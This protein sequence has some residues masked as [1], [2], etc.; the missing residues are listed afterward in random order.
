MVDAE[1][2]G[3]SITVSTRVV[4]SWKI[5]QKRFN[6]ECIEVLVQH[7]HFLATQLMIVAGRDNRM[8]SLKR[9]REESLSKDLSMM[10]SGKAT[11]RQPATRVRMQVR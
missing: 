1:F 3:R 9:A 7:P 2:L 6:R 5:L 4:A 8:P 11:K 10:L